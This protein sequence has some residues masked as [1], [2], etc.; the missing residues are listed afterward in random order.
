LQEITCYKGVYE[1]GNINLVRKEK[2]HIELVDIPEGTQSCACSW[3]LSLPSFALHHSRH[4]FRNQSGGARNLQIEHFS[5]FE[6]ET[7]SCWRTG[8]KIRRHG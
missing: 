5:E 6:W 8:N 4:L 3:K 2:E 7:E 1:N